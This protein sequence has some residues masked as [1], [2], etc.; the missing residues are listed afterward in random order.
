MV[1]KIP[2]CL[3][4]A[5]SFY[6]SKY[7]CLI[8]VKHSINSVPL[9]IS[10]PCPTFLIPERF[11]VFQVHGI[12]IDSIVVFCYY[13]SLHIPLLYYIDLYSKAILQVRGSNRKS[14]LAY[15]YLLR[16]PEPEGVGSNHALPEKISIV[17]FPSIE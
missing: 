9:R 12:V 11:E 17:Y 7:S 15:L 10:E 5:N 6:S 8:S 4:M 14:K 13:A 3:I 1:F 16:P 2:I